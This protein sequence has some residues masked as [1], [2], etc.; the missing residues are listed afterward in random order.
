MRQSYLY[1]Y[2]RENNE[3]HV[4]VSRAKPYHYDGL[5]RLKDYLNSRPTYKYSPSSFGTKNGIYGY[6]DEEK[7][8]SVIISPNQM[9]IT[10][11]NH[12]E[13]I[14]IGQKHLSAGFN[15]NG[16]SYGK[17]FDGVINSPW[18]TFIGGKRDALVDNSTKA[19]AIREFME[20][21]DLVLLNSDY[22]S[23]PASDTQDSK[24]IRKNFYEKAN[25]NIRR[26]YPE[27]SASD[28]YALEMDKKEV[29]LIRN[30][31]NGA[32]IIP[33]VKSDENIYTEDI[34]EIFS[35]IDEYKKMRRNIILEKRELIIMT[36]SQLRAYF[37]KQGTLYLADEIYKNTWAKN[38]S[39]FFISF[40]PSNKAGL[41][42]KLEKIINDH[43][44]SRLF[45]QG[46]ENELKK[47]EADIKG[48]QPPAS[49][50]SDILPPVGQ[51]S[52]VSQGY[53]HLF[54]H[55]SSQWTLEEY[56]SDPNRKKGCALEPWR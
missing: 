56:I 8:Q 15:H 26:F 30:R 41:S 36:V 3:T 47:L 18:I 20:E 52:S 17:Y 54:Y 22:K 49:H 33:D 12:I 7:K 28:L 51:Y 53:G 4:L 9:I 11:K 46:I 14:A 43:L 2:Y 25:A 38:F 55:P 6:E 23:Y 32:P 13:Q 45:T 19:T 21:T 42:Q 5:V 44:Q 16:Y 48:V 34:V 27:N 31:F 35:K 40:L 50:G 1:V 39:D 10:L 37:N 24:N 29:E